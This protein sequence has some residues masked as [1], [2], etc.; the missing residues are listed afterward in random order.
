MSNSAFAHPDV[1]FVGINV[2]EMDAFKH[3]AIPVV[4]DARVAIDEIAS[5]VEGFHHQ[6]DYRETVDAVADVS[7]MRKSIA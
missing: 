1:R 2:C 5:R 3:A 7:G 6:R 4:A